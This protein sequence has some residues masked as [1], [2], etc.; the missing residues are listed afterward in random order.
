[1]YDAAD[2]EL[3]LFGLIVMNTLAHSVAV[4]NMQQGDNTDE[5]DYVAVGLCIQSIYLFV[6]H[7]CCI[8][9]LLL[10]PFSVS[11]M[12]MSL[13]ISWWCLYATLLVFCC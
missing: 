1:M 12:A 11:A 3:Q 4:L 13:C 2:E 5:T 10:H 9:I 7:H 8:C 6:R